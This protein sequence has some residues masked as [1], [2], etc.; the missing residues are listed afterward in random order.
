LKKLK[1]H[2]IA[3]IEEGG[4]WKKVWSE[5]KHLYFIGEEE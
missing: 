3:E 1:Y 2:I 5:L 4:Q